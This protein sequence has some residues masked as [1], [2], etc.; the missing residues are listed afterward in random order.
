[1]GEGGRTFEPGESAP[2]LSFDGEL[3]LIIGNH[4]D[5]LHDS[6]GRGAPLAWEQARQR[7]C[8]LV[9]TVSCGLI[10]SGLLRRTSLFIR[11]GGVLPLCGARRRALNRRARWVTLG[12]SRDGGSLSLSRSGRG[13]R[14]RD[15][16]CVLA[17]GGHLLG[18]ARPFPLI[19]W[20]CGVDY[21]FACAHARCSPARRLR[22]AYAACA[23]CKCGAA[24]AVARG[25]VCVG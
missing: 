2:V 18:L 17:C 22:F 7:L 5:T 19:P 9:G 11:G 14:R 13:A 25:C 1:M 21:R 20:R 16:F 8:V 15:R 12:I 10:A 4:T 23:L 3:L 6:L 24:R